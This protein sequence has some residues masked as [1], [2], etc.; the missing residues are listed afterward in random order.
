VEVNHDDNLG[1]EAKPAVQKNGWASTISYGLQ[2]EG[3]ITA[4]PADPSDHLNFGQELADRANR[5][6]FN[7]AL[8]S[9][10]R[11][12][13]EGR[14]VDVGFNLQGLFGTDA[15]YTPTIG[16]LDGS[17]KGR[18]Q[19]VFTQANIVLHTPILTQGGIDFRIGLAPGAM[20]YEGIDPATRPFFT[21][22][23]ITNFMVPFQTAGIISTIHATPK[24]DIYAGIDAG[25]EVLPGK[26]DNNHRAAGYF[27]IGLNHLA[28]DRLTILAMARFGPENAL[29]SLPNAD[30]EMRYWNDITATYKLS[31]RT[32][33]VA[34]ANYIED[35]GLKA[36]AFAIAGYASHQINNTLTANL[37]AE[38]MRDSNG[39]FVVGFKTD[40]AFTQAITGTGDPNSY[41]SAPPTTYGEL[42]AG[43]AWKPARLNGR[44]VTMTVRPELRYETSLNGTRPFNTLTSRDQVLASMDLIIGL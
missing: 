18:Y 29:H 5:P 16:V 35:K 15:R 34:E 41:V 6:L 8:A 1:T 44:H 40:T 11:P 3:S 9:V 2:F 25:N 37:R 24:L 17:L 38:V 14:D 31:D 36:H 23:Y 28:H 27:G 42:T 19:F 4:N 26:S 33:F 10:A 30:H 21:L 39:A 20:G 7:Q 43:V 12:V 22:S 32:T 13:S